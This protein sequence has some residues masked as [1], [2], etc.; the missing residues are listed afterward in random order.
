M[1]LQDI[2]S[3]IGNGNYDFGEDEYKES[4]TLVMPGHDVVIE[5]VLEPLANTFA[6]LSFE[7]GNAEKTIRY[8]YFSDIDYEN[9][10][11]I[12]LEDENENEIKEQYWIKRNE[13]NDFIA[14][15]GIII[16]DI[17]LE[18]VLFG[19]FE[20]YQELLE[21]ANEYSLKIKI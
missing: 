11:S 13:N 19:P 1:F 10:N 6:I 18:D 4:F 15:S 8:E 14:V 12:K 3:L 9:T 16:G 17:K 5:S 21:C 7:K 2:H 20:T